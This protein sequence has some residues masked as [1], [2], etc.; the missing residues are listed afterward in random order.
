MKSSPFF[1][2]LPKKWSHNLLL[3]IEMYSE[4]QK[5]PYN[6]TTF[7]TKNFKNSPICDKLWTIYEHK[8]RL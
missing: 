7:V 8:L 4:P 5:S 6:G 3:K 1:E 2:T